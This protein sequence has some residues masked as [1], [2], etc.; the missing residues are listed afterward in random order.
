MS[1]FVLEQQQSFK[2]HGGAQYLARV[3]AVLLATTSSVL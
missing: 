3:V 1:N 2:D